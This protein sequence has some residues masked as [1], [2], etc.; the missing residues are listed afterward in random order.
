VS[1]AFL[2]TLERAGADERGRFRIDQLLIE[3]FGRDPNAVG[4]VG[5]FELGEK[6]EQGR[7]V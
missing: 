3:R 5:E 6:V 4:D 1:S 7:L 2:G